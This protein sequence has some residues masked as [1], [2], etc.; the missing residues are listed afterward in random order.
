LRMSRKFPD[1]ESKLRCSVM[2]SPYYFVGT[3]GHVTDETDREQQ[4]E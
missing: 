2:W 4:T 1:I 3:A